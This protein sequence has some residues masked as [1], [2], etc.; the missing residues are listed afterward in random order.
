MTGAR[1]PRWID[2]ALLGARLIMTF[3]RH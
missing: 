1:H 2:T 3:S